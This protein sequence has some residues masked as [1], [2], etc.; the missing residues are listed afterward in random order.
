[1][2][3]LCKGKGDIISKTGNVEKITMG[4]VSDLLHEGYFLH[5]DIFYNSVLL[6]E[7]FPLNKTY[8]YGLTGRRTPKKRLEDK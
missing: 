6:A 5:V 3:T 8:L 7:H 2:A 4:F 1:M